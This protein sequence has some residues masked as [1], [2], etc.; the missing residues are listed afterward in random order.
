MEDGGGLPVVAAPPAQDVSAFVAQAV[1]AAFGAV[2]VCVEVVLRA[3]SRAGG[4]G[5][6]EPGALTAA[7]PVNVT[8]LTDATLGLGWTVVRM[9]GGVAG[10]V[11]RVGGTVVRPVAG[12]VVSP[13]L[14]PRALWPSTVVARMSGSWRAQRPD[15][16]A[17]LGRWSQ[18]V[19]P[20]AVDLAFELVDV[21]RVAGAVVD[22]MDVPAVVDRVLD[23]LDLDHTVSVV[24]ARLDL[25]AVVTTALADLDLDRVVGDAVARVDIATLVEQV[26]AEIDLTALV[27]QRVDLRAV[28]DDV[29]DQ[30][31]LTQLVMDRV[32][33]AAVAERVIDDID[34]PE[35]IRES[36]G[37]IAYETVRGIR[38]QSVD[39]DRAVERVV[40]RILLRRR[41][42]RTQA[43]QDPDRNPDGD[44]T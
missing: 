26:I 25:D 22:R 20:D 33:L 24:L 1:A 39:A 23:R 36:T 34:L 31:D 16:V 29:L 30:L 4:P 42:R 11:G 5:P 43:P 10:A 41:G 37:S 15:S 7:K 18:S 9:G 2:A 44:P 38:L 6:A 40:D 35:I 3:A 17:A 12:V 8:T 32:D 28:V 27:T 14:V 21:D 13:P 19:A